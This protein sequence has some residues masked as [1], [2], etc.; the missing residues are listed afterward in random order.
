MDCTLV[1][2][3]SSTTSVYYNFS[4][5]LPKSPDVHVCRAL[6]LLVGKYDQLISCHP[7]TQPTLQ[8]QDGGSSSSNSSF[9][10]AA[11]YRPLIDAVYQELTER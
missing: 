8:V 7:L 10:P 5:C 11:Q 4:L 9:Q 3:L 6:K 2:S 1:F